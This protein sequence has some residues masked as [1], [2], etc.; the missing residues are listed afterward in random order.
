M[1][2]EIWNH[3]LK[4][5]IEEPDVVEV[6]IPDGVEKID[7]YAFEKC[8]SIVSITI[9]QSVTE[10]GSMAF[11]KCTNLTSIIIPKS[12]KDISFCAFNDTPWFNMLKDEFVIVGNGILIKYN[13][14]DINVVIPYGVKKIADTAF[15]KRSDIIEVTIPE[16]VTKI[17]DYAFENCS[18]LQTVTLP[19]SLIKI[20][21]EAFYKCVQLSSI[22]IPP[23]VKEIGIFAFSHC[24]NLHTINIPD[25]ITEIK[26]RTFQFCKNLEAIT[27]PESVTKICD[28]AFF[29]CYK[30]RSVTIPPTV[31]TIESRAFDCTYFVDKY[32][33]NFV[34]VNGILINY[35]GKEENV[36]IPDTV[37]EI[38]GY[39]FWC[40][41]FI[42]PIKT[43][44]IPDTVR[45]IH[46]RAFY[47]RETLQS[48]AIKPIKKTSSF[49]DALL[50]KNKKLSENSP[51]ATNNVT[52]I[53]GRAFCDCPN[54]QEI[55]FDCATEIHTSAFRDCPSLKSIKFLKNIIGIM[56]CAF[57]NISSTS[58]VKIEILTDSVNKIHRNAFDGERNLIYVPHI[59]ITSPAFKKFGIGLAKSFANLFINGEKYDDEVVTANKEYI[60]SQSQELC[61]YVLKSTPL[62]QYMILEKLIPYEEILPLIEKTDDVS[63]KA[64]LLEYQNSNFPQHKTEPFS[65]EL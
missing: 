17:C 39:V 22:Y 46:E 65:Y 29:G 23:R 11:H 21:T 27:I 9:P 37:K 44:T 53:D 58:D 3:I 52:T 45:R 40:K 56:G 51:D 19:N 64:M 33:D 30:L 42:D 54:L 16:G 32:K 5:Y 41:D 59:P 49:L 10:I 7:N 48:V 31:K 24:T 47:E 12:V 14:N 20:G 2:F 43:I 38:T 62:L 35:K 18:N 28:H 60:K 25:N 8:G 55:I 4:K 36:V 50:G 63:I 15:R 6:V 13:G 1:G 26:D 34:V 61:D 57:L